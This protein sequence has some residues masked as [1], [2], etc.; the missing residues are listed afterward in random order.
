MNLLMRLIRVWISALFKRRL[1]LLEASVLKFRVWPNDLD[2]YGHMNNG[3]YLTIMDLGRMDL[4]IRTGMV[5]ISGKYRWNPLVASSAMRHKKA[6]SFF[7]RYELSSRIVCWDERW[8][9]IE[10]RFKSRGHE[11]AAGW[12]KGLFY[13]PHG[14]VPTSEVIKVLN[15]SSESPAMPSSIKIW[16]ESEKLGKNT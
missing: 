16:L 6:L 11:V 4:M 12:I 8:F 15:Y 1:G 13:G 7:Q 3:R 9:F 10:Q 5:R 2:I 14:K